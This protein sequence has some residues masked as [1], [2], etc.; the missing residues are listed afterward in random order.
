MSVFHLINKQVRQQELLEGIVNKFE[1]L[2]T[3]CHENVALEM[4]SLVDMKSNS[5]VFKFDSSF[6][7]SFTMSFCKN[8]K[9]WY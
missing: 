3:G 4:E 5:K 1:P 7:D 9:K 8:E 2:F 6:S